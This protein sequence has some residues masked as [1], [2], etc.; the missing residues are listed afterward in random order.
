MF[1]SEQM[2]LQSLTTTCDNNTVGIVMTLTADVCLHEVTSKFGANGLVVK[3]SEY[4]SITNSEI[5]LL[6][7]E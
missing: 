1:L 7:Q 3:E 2:S 5:C 6:P 4:I